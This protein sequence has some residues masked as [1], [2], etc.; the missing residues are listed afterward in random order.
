M[1]EESVDVVVRGIVKRVGWV[2]AI[3]EEE[4]EDEDEVLV[5]A[6]LEEAVC[7]ERRKDARFFCRE[8]M[9]FSSIW[10]SMSAAS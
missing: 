3:E 2:R 7:D 5:V 8:A 9:M 4:E 10:T 1:E 6:D